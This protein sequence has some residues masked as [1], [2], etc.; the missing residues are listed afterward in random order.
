[1]PVDVS[2]VV[3]TYKRVD[4]LVRCLAALIRQDYPPTGYEIIVADDAAC[5][6]TRQRVDRL[7]QRVCAQRA[8]APA[9]RYLPVVGQ[10]GPA[11]ARNAGWRAACGRYIAFTDDDTIPDLSWLRAGV[12]ALANGADGAAGRV[13][14]PLPPQ[15]S[16][17]ERDVSRLM[18]GKFVTA[19]C[20]YR[21]DLLEA[22]GGFDER[23]A[24]AWRED[25]DLFFTLIS[26]G[27]CL[28]NVPDAIVEHPIRPARWGMSICQQRKSFYNALLYK[29]HPYAYRRYIQATP[30]WHYYGI[31]V[32]L[33]L[34]I[35]ALLSWDVPLAIV[36]A[37]TWLLLTGRFCLRRL[38]GT[39]HA[40]PHI[41]EMAVT[42]ALIPLLSVY[43]RLRGA[44]TFRVWFF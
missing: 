23:F 9:L 4:L 30:P 15:P 31:V 40:L 16:D 27:A 5:P 17:Y 36:A 34:L 41:L 14:V 33:G 18:E 21:R 22:V 12:A 43:W 19:N 2:V 3:P 28:V 42:S 7:A 10:H 35:V 38:R 32:A 1:M 20:F 24:V 6:I 29:K 37:S 13:I 11:A 39:S 26:R 25:S 8:C 44:I